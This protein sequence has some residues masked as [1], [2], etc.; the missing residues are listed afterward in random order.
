MSWLLICDLWVCVCLISIDQALSASPISKC[1]QRCRVVPFVSMSY[2][3]HVRCRCCCLH[4]SPPTRR[5]DGIS[6][7]LHTYQMVRS[8]GEQ[9]LRLMSSNLFRLLNYD[10]F[11]LNQLFSSKHKVYI[12][13]CTS[14]IAACQPLTT[15]HA[16]TKTKST[17]KRS[18]VRPWR[19]D[20]RR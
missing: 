2:V 1:S 8:I 20:I 5:V 19:V 11:F 14:R 13:Q 10:P 3:V 18:I 6:F 4:R 16:A 15:R 9:N 17:N 12:L 7:T